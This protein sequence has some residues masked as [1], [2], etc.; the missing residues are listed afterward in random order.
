MAELKYLEQSL[1]NQ[2]SVH[3][4]I[5]RSLISGNACYRLVENVLSSRFLSKNK[6]KYL[7]TYL[8]TYSM[9]QSPSWE[10]NWF[11][12]SQEI[13]RILWKPMVHYRVSL[14]LE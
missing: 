8:L 14:S 9:E 11:S 2:N 4:E 7:L 3:E 12:A 10:S 6:A 1:T 5:K 13:S